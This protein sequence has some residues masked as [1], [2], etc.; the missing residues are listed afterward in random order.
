MPTAPARSCSDVAHHQASMDPQAHGQQPP[1]FVRQAPLALPQGVEHLEPGSPAALPPWLM[2]RQDS[3][4]TTDP[5]S[6]TGRSCAAG[7]WLDGQTTS[8]AT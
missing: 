3:Q 8:G 2:A 6:H 7:P 4:R 1:P 5:T